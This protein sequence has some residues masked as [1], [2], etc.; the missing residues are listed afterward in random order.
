MRTVRSV[1]RALGALTA[2]LLAVPA[3]VLAGPPGQASAAE[4][5]HQQASRTSA[6]DSH[7][8]AISIT[9]LS[10]SY[11]RQGSK[12]T[13]TGTVAN[14]TGAAVSGIAVQ[15]WTATEVFNG[16][17]EMTSFGD[18]GSY[19]Y[20]LDPAGTAMVT[21]TV[22]N[23][24]TLRWS[25]SFPAA[26]FYDQFGV[27][28]VQVQATSLGGSYK[29]AAQTFLPYW[30]G[31][32]A[33]VQPKQLQV[34]WILPL[35]DAPQ[36]GACSRTLATNQLAGSVASG[37]RLS[38]LL[39]AGAA[40]GD[41]D[42]VTWDIDPALLSDVS[43]MKSQYSTLGNA[44]CSGRFTQ[45]ASKAAASWLTQLSSATGGQPAFLTPYANVDVAA[46][47]HAGLQ[48]N[49]RTAYQLGEKVAG[50]ILPTTFGTTGTGSG[51]GSVL[52]AA[53]PAD[54]VADAGVLTDLANLGGVNTVVLRSGQLPSATPYD[55][56]IANTTS[57]IGTQMSVLLADS[58]ITSLLGSASAKPSAAAQ[59]TLTQDFLAQTAM[60]SSEA[61]GVSH[62]LVVAPPTDWDPSPAEA[63]ALLRITHETPWLSSTGLSALAAQAAKLPS[64]ALPANRVSHAELHGSYLDS[65]KAVDASL[66]VF[67]NLLY[68]PPASQVTSLQEAVAATASSAWRGEGSEG[69]W[70]AMYHLTDYLRHAEHMVQIIPTKRVLL[71]GNSGETPVSVKNGLSWPVRVRVTA[72]TPADSQLRVGPYPTPLTVQAGKTNTVR[73][74]VHA[75]S[76][77]TTTVQLQLVTEDGSP[78]TWTAQKLSVE[79][80]RV[81]RFLL[82]IIGGALGILL[83][84]SVYRLRRKRL[85]AAA[86][87]GSAVDKDDSG[88]AG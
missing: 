43:V 75:A 2:V 76:I 24:K 4:S 85:A 3:L 31:K 51:D 7:T 40:W 63:T 60:I 28:P 21:G 64:Q 41:T 55:N 84:T 23:G 27:F 12:V 45:P 81:G 58:E 9:G 6:A 10:P 54:G 77:G 79:V 50:Q 66:A 56:A 34:A 70:L 47:S 14:H 67:T 1:V 48:A 71:A 46:L 16:R 80:T 33:T 17:S 32:Q 78:L 15:A 18:T 37:G 25:V 57:G 52:K 38:T 49:L 22:P 19:P 42:N 62:S 39:D 59:F 44:T 13:V 20:A 8:L 29:T 72:L 65:F 26:G 68:Q 87:D 11:A 88:G 83:L 61:P 73:M 36:Q 69:G 53:W 86:G 35:V 74:P 5:Q 82:T 30:P